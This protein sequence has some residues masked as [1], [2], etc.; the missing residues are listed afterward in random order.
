MHLSEMLSLCRHKIIDPFYHREIING[1][2]M[3]MI[4]LQFVCRDFDVIF[5]YRICP[6][7][8]RICLD[9]ESNDHLCVFLRD[10]APCAYTCPFFSKL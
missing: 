6:D 10:P 8:F 2:S 7:P 9:P 4:C 3:T 1:K 5:S